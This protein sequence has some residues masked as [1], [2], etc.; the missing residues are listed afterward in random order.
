[1]QGSSP[2]VRC[3]LSGCKAPSFLF[4]CA[5]WGKEQCFAEVVQKNLR[6]SLSYRQV[7]CG[8][9]YLQS[10][11]IYQEWYNFCFPHSWVLA[12][13][14][15]VAGCSGCYA[16]HLPSPSLEIWMNSPLSVLSVGTDLLYHSI[17]TPTSGET[18]KNYCKEE[19]FFFLNSASDFYANSK[20]Y[21]VPS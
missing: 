1:M 16:G 15:K 9:L 18:C 20:I 7:T 13:F 8:R 11:L 14:C 2:S 6:V 10:S 5:V 21:E 17:P 12:W 3:V 4:G 19:R